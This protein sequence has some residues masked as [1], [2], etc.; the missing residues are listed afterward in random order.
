MCG[1]LGAVFGGHPPEFTCLRLAVVSGSTEIEMTRSRNFFWNSDT[2]TELR[3]LRRIQIRVWQKRNWVFVQKNLIVSEY[4]MTKIANIWNRRLSHSDMD[5]FQS[6]MHPTYLEFYIW[7]PKRVHFF[8]T[9]NYHLWQ[10]QPLQYFKKTF[11]A[12]SV[13]LTKQRMYCTVQKHT[14]KSLIYREFRNVRGSD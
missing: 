10:D 11:L 5:S 13:V 14:R 1:F 6:S 2:S 9:G 4:H 12:S 7:P 3:F 8:E